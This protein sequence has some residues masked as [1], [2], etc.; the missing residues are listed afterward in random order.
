MERLSSHE[1]SRIALQ[2]FQ[3]STP[4]SEVSLHRAEPSRPAVGCARFPWPCLARRRLPDLAARVACGTPCPARRQSYR[5]RRKEGRKPGLARRG[6]ARRGVGGPPGP[7]ARTLHWVEN[8]RHVNTL[9][10]AAVC[11]TAAVPAAG[12]RRRRPPCYIGAR[13]ASSAP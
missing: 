3:S 9:R 10:L 5:E 13:P 12:A 8:S 2:R 11:S 4:A 6:E 1:L 7:Y